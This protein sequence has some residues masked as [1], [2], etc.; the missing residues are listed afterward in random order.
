[1]AAAFR[2]IWGAISVNLVGTREAH[3]EFF[4]SFAR[5]MI[6]SCGSIVSAL[7]NSSADFCQLQSTLI[8]P[9]EG[10]KLGVPVCAASCILLRPSVGN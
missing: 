1:M 4:V 9:R 3:P 8:G 10:T 5:S 6:R 7:W 2:R